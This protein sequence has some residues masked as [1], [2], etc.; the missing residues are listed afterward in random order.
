[1]PLR[2]TA[3]TNVA[4][5]GA[6]STSFD[7]CHKHGFHE[8]ELEAMAN[9]KAILNRRATQAIFEDRQTSHQHHRDTLAGPRTSG[10]DSANE[11]TTY[12]PGSAR[13]SP[14][15]VAGTVSWSSA[16]KSAP[17]APTAADD[18]DAPRQ[19]RRDRAGKVYYAGSGQRRVT[20]EERASWRSSEISLGVV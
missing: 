3:A 14:G 6:G 10:M 19:V 8:D 5:R 18:V 13:G 2:S 1:M 20:A 11:E 7:L 9:W 12:V 15:T 4:S 17:P 16:A